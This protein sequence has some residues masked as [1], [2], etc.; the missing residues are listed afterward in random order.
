MYNNL[1]KSIMKNLVLKS[2]VAICAA[3]L[4]VSAFAAT[5]STSEAVEKTASSTAVNTRAEEAHV[6][7]I[8]GALSLSGKMSLDNIGAIIVLLPNELRDCLCDEYRNVL[9]TGGN[10]SQFSYNGVKIKHNGN[11]WEFSYKN[12][13]LKVINATPEMLEKIFAPRSR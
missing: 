12:N 10:K 8:I 5:P 4:S 7:Y 1:N 6:E 2:A 9:K 11:N 3:I 13:T